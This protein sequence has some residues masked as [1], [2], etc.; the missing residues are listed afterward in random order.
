MN[1]IF[2]DRELAKCVNE[3][4]LLVREYGER[5][6][7]I[8]RRRLSELAAATVLDDLRNLPAARCHELRG[9]RRG[10]LAVDLDHPYRLIFE[11]KPPPPRKEDGGLDWQRV[12]EI[13]VLEI[14]NYH[15]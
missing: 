11:P 2:Y 3:Y 5:R 7:K 4:R 1:I 12:T 13:V 15:D 6:A 14:T 10:Q 9:N 8:I